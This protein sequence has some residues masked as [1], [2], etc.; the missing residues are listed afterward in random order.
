MISVVQAQS[1]PAV[2][3]QDH[4]PVLVSV[5]ELTKSYG[6]RTAVRDV[7]FEARPGVTGLLGPNGDGKSTLLRC[8]AGLSGWD[9]GE[10]RIG[11]DDPA[12]RVA[13]ARREIGFMPERV[14]L[15]LEM[16]V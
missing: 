14:A 9:S 13:A 11:G 5:S 7:S 6:S 2:E 3:T 1:P 12:R 10:I 15:P 4:A 8:L 16:R